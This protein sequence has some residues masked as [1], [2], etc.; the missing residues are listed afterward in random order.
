ME[1]KIEYGL[2]GVTSYTAYDNGRME[3]CRLSAYNVIPTKYGQLVPQY[4][5][6]GIRRK[7]SKAL[8]FYPSGSLRS[9]S[10]DSQT[11]ITTGLGIF[12]AEFISFYEDGSIDSLFP[13]N[14]RISFSWSE[15]EEGQ[16]AGKY[17]FDLSIGKFRAKLSGLRFYPDGGL[18]SLI[19]WPGEIIR[20][21]TPVGWMPIRI[22]F[23]LYEDG[24]LESVEPAEPVY[25]NTPAGPIK[26]YDTTAIGVDADRNSLRFDRKGNLLSL[27]TSGDIV[28]VNKISGDRKI[29]SSRI[30]PGLM[31][32]DFIKLPVYIAFAEQKIMIDN[33]EEQAGYV[34]EECLLNIVYDRELGESACYGDCSLCKGCS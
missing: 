30:R 14:G 21:H 28:V 12:P 22:G 31:E 32:E 23:K 24:S 7:D 15:E 9:I 8:S 16:L 18:K 6:P 1:T 5:N 26:A 10:I 13:L 33:G 17:D 25:V 19:L 29:V 20:I 2:N 4:R 11:G 27:A 3:K 34:T